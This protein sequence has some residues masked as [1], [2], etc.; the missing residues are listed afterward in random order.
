MSRTT[1]SSPIHRYGGQ[2]TK[3]SVSSY[4]WMI[5]AYVLAGAVMID[6]LS[7]LSFAQSTKKRSQGIVA[8]VNDEPI[9]SYEVKQRENLMM[10][11]NRSVGKKA[12]ATMQRLFK[13]KATTEKLKGILRKVIDANRGKSREQILA[14]FEKRKKA[15]AVK[16]QRQAL[17]QARA[18]A[19]KGIGKKALDELINERLQMQEAKK[20]NV[21]AS[22]DDAKK[23]V[24][25]IAKRNKMTFKQFSAHLRKSGADV[26]SMQEKFRANMSWANVVRRQF[27]RQLQ[28]SSR[29]IDRWTRGNNTASAAGGD[30]TSTLKLQRVTFAVASNTNDANFAQMLQQAADLRSRHTNCSQTPQ[31][32]Q[33]VVGARFEDLGARPAGSIAEPTRTMLLNAQPGE[34]LPATVGAAGV[35]VWILCGK[36]SATAQKGGSSGPSPTG[37]APAQKQS[38]EEK[39]RQQQ[40]RMMSSRHLRDLR[41]DA[42]IEYR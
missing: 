15:F 31:I 18:Q 40:F 34:M 2:Q 41:Q 3:A 16:L 35:E 32:A 42:H 39:K 28:A 37:R 38:A 6:G 8:L 13:R 30:E 12:Q 25:S 5:C 26:N 24:T 27:G 19:R 4:R 29:D 23:R 1:T 11:S 21:L 10:L 7:H 17:S 14:I 33:Q 22:K 20:L 36:G 9:T